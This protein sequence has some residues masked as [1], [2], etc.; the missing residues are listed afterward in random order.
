MEGRL[1]KMAGKNCRDSR[2]VGTGIHGSKNMRNGNCGME[3]SRNRRGGRVVIVSRED[4][5]TRKEGRKLG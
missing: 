1:R 4:R 3:G 2:K 5:T